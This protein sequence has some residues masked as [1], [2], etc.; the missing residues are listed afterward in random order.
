MHNNR[1][2]RGNR[3]RNR[4]RNQSQRQSG[5]AP[6]AASAKNKEVERRNKRDEQAQELRA[7][8]RRWLQKNIDEKVSLDDGWLVIA[9]DLK[10]G[11]VKVRE[12]RKEWLKVLPCGDDP[13]LCFLPTDEFNAKLCLELGEQV[14]WLLTQQLHIFWSVVLFEESF[15]RM[16]DSFLRYSPRPW[17]QQANNVNQDF[18]QLYALAFRLAVRL[19]ERVCR[20]SGRP[21]G[22][23][24][25]RARV[26]DVFWRPH[27]LL[28]FASLYY[29]RNRCAVVELVDNAEL[30]AHVDW[31]DTLRQVGVVLDQLGASSNNDAALYLIDIAYQCFF[32]ERVFHQRLEPPTRG[33][34][35]SLLSS[36][37]EQRQHAMVLEHFGIV[38]SHAVAAS[39]SPSSSSSPAAAATT[40]VRKDQ[41]PELSE[42]FSLL[43]TGDE[44]QED[45][46][47]DLDDLFE[48]VLDD[49]LRDAILYEYEDDYDETEDQSALSKLT[50]T[51]AESTER[52]EV[53]D[54]DSSVADEEA[55]NNKNDD[56]GG[57]DDDDDDDDEEEEGQSLSKEERFLKRKQSMGK[58]FTKSSYR[59]RN[60]QR[61][62]RKK[63]AN[64][65]RS[66]T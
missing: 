44:R 58:S 25:W 35:V 37:D 46:M 56:G 43:T 17:Q 3:N 12:L 60:Q 64:L 28:D 61:S 45:V 42:L 53:D 15:P 13:F 23:E 52:G 24:F 8:I 9:N 38:K 27:A 41:P 57:G 65:K 29:V 33:A 7:T 32:L 11:A 4:N 34:L 66:I 18:E 5:G 63:R 59:Q 39:S 62:Y 19:G 49:K 2:G 30:G 31:S 54:D 48:P 47:R 14:L 51:M 1:G 50:M 55:E 22:N 6:A 16:F 10:S 40:S 20:H 21:I 36:I 26:L